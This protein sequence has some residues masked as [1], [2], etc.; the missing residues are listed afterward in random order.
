MVAATA[1]ADIELPPVTSLDEMLAEPEDPVRFRIDRVWP[2]G[3]AMG[4]CAAAAGAGKTTLDTN[5]IRSL[6]DGDPFLGAFTV[7][8]RAERIVV[9]TT[10]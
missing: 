1:A 7:H 3:G 2:A 5:M 8:Q 10:R 9:M 6:A 4:L